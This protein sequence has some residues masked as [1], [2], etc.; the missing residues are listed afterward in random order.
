M[1]TYASVEKKRENMGIFG[2]LLQGV[3]IETRVRSWTGQYFYSDAIH[4]DYKKDPTSIIVEPLLNKL[5]GMNVIGIAAGLSRMALAVIHSIGHLFAALLTFKM[6]HVV[7]VAK[8]ACEF[9]RGFIEAIPFIGRKFAEVYYC[10][11]E[12]WIIKI[13]NPDTP[14]TLDDFARKWGCFKQNRPSAYFSC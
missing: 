2:D 1:I 8:G 14:D 10:H 13:Y 12:W 4:H 3:V 5:A 6:G 11:G 9:L 7:H